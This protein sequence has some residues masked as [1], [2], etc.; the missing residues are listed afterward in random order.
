MCSSCEVM[1]RESMCNCCKENPLAMKKIEE[2]A[3]TCITQ[4]P[5]FEAAMLTTLTLDIAYYQFKQEAKDRGWNPR[6]DLQQNLNRFNIYIY[7]ISFNVGE[8]V[9]KTS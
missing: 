2:A 1:D 5:M 3:I 4:F 6:S 8:N 7:Y 9:S